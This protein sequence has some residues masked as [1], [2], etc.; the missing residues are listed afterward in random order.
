MTHVQPDPTASWWR[1]LLATEP[2]LVKGVIGAL[3]ALG[4]VWGVDFTALGDQLSRTADIVGSIVALLT[5]L[6]IRQSVSP[7]GD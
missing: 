1:R 2:A 6:W 7:A 5:P 4:L 3:V